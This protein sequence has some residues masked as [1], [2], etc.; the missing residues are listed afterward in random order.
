MPFPRIEILETDVGTHDVIKYNWKGKPTTREIHCLSEVS[1]GEELLLYLQDVPE[2]I[3]KTLDTGFEKSRRK[4]LIHKILWF[5]DKL[6]ELDS[7]KYP[8]LIK[9]VKTVGKA[10]DVDEKADKHNYFYI[11]LTIS[12]IKWWVEIIFLA[13]EGNDELITISI[14]PNELGVID[15]YFLADYLDNTNKP[16]SY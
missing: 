6:H 9:K 15:R 2:R 7:N 12:F 16:Y 8:G 3:G 5:Q 11:P 10:L 1:I 14:T 13:R 4:H